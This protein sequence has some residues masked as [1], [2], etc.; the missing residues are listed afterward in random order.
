MR[1]ANQLSATA[2]SRHEPVLLMKR[3]SP[4]RWQASTQ[5][6]EVYSAP[7]MLWKIVPSMRCWPRVVTAASSAPRARAAS[8]WVPIE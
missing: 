7:R 8:W 6:L 4:S 2:L 5:A 3:R 1:E